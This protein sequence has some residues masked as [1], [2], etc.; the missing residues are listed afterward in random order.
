MTFHCKT[1][2]ANCAKI[3]LNCFRFS[4]SYERRMVKLHSCTSSIT[5][6]CLGPGGLESNLLQVVDSLNNR[7]IIVMCINILVCFSHNCNT[8]TNF[9]KEPIHTT[10]VCKLW[11]KL[12][13]LNKQHI[14]ECMS[15]VYTGMIVGLFHK[16]LGLLR[17]RIL[18]LKSISFF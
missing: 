13:F 16:N 9:Y 4:L 17:E 14:L 10:D 15:A 2:N 11:T 8:Q 7:L 12:A 1:L 6:S 5:Q 18:I 3:C